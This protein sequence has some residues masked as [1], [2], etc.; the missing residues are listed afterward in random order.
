MAGTM[1][2]TA[3]GGGSAAAR[4]VP[5]FVRFVVF[6]GGVTLLGSGALLLIGD[7]APVAAANAV[8]TVVTTLLATELHTRFTFRRGRASWSDHCASG[9]TVLL[10]YL[11]TT[12]AL[13]GYDACHT[14]GGALVRQGVYLAA[15]GAAG[16]AR[17][18][19]L[20]YVFARTRRVPRAQSPAARR[21]RT[22]W[23]GRAAAAAVPFSRAARALRTPLP[24][25]GR[26]P[27]PVSFTGPVASA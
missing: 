16:I 23:A 1:T 14:G 7:R 11:F 19:L 20:R 10:S 25:P 18:L 2:A 15:S 6:G 17:F 27:E 22:A 24:A 21:V 26:G 3:T 4:A 9:L 13:I 12:G 5:A 8:V